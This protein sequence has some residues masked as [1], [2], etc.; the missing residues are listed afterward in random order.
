[1][2]V[3]VA[4][5]G[6]CSR[7][8]TI[9]VPPQSIHEHMESM[10]ASANQRVR[11]KGF[12]QGKVPRKVLEKHLG[13]Q[14]LA[15]AK[16]QL[17]NRFFNEACQAQEISPIGQVVV[18]N[19]DELEVVP[20]SGLEFSVQVN[21]RPTF[22]LGE[23][24]GLEASSYETEVTDADLDG[25][26]REIANQKRSIRKVDEPSEKGD[27]VKVDLEFQ[28]DNGIKVHE[29][30][31]VQLNTTIPVAGT[32]QAA[33]EAA[34]T[35]VEAGNSIELPLTFP[36]NFEKDEYRG[37]PGKAVLQVLEI[38]RVAAP[39]IDDQLAG[40]LDFEN[41][42]ALQT[43]LRTRIGNEKVRAGRQRQE[44]ECL[45]QLVGQHP[46]ELPSALIEEQQQASLKA[47]AE[48]LHQSGMAE[49][50]IQSK[51][52]ESTAEAQEDAT[53]RVRLFFLIE[54]VARAEKLFVTEGDID[55]EV[56]RIAQ[57]NDASPAQ[58]R[59]HLQQNKQLGELRLTV[60]ER[61]VRDFLRDNAKIVDRKGN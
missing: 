34:L 61:K 60:L 22:E 47:Y 20:N 46:F 48:R 3:Q 12:R 10:Y 58:V 44:E 6:P 30:T 1:M 25:A 21:V 27:F 26:L 18:D 56:K 33:F 4:E 29:R 43:D 36:A 9:Q 39:P 51:V 49:A 7:K 2:Q 55:T 5:T 40:S 32:D 8:L 45:Q 38:M 15:E 16:Q 14:I 24:K 17:V 13:V 31:G 57:A 50:E 54:E 42:E 41:L 11:L 52:E 37:K 23:T 28:D 53:R 19:F 59:D 35:G